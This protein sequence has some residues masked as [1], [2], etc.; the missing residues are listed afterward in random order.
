VGQYDAARQAYVARMG[1][2]AA[3]LEAAVMRWAREQIAEPHLWF[4]LDRVAMPGSPHSIMVRSNGRALFLE[5]RPLGGPSSVNQKM[6]E[7]GLRRL[8]YHYEVLRSV[9]QLCSLLKTAGVQLAGAAESMA[10][11]ADAKLKPRLERAIRTR[12]VALKR[13]TNTAA[14]VGS[15][16]T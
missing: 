12:R 1:P 7:A 5:F 13:R 9:A 4:S 3:A 11:T 15:K 2:E 14:A 10:S 8:G 16:E 6:V